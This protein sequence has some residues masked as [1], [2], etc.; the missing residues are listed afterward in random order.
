MCAPVAERQGALFEVSKRAARPRGAP[1]RGAGLR[2]PG[3]GRWPAPGGR[4]E[5]LQIGAQQRHGIGQR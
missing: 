3:R 5:H 4:G 1:R 2:L